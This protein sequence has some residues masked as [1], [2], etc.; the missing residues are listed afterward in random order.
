MNKVLFR[1]M[2]VGIGSVL[3]GYWGCFA[4]AG[5]RHAQPKTPVRRSVQPAPKPSPSKPVPSTSQPSS[6]SPVVTTPEGVLAALFDE[7]EALKN[8][9]IGLDSSISQHID[10]QKA[11]EGTKLVDEESQIK[12]MM[13]ISRLEQEDREFEV[14][15]ASIMKRLEDIEHQISSLLQAQAGQQA[16]KVQPMGIDAIV[17]AHS[18]AVPW[19]GKLL[20]RVIDPATNKEKIF[21]KGIAGASKLFADGKA[22]VIQ[23]GALG[24]R[25]NPDDTNNYCGYYV[26]F[27]IWLLMEAPDGL[28]GERAIFASMF[29]GMLQDMKQKG[30]R[31]PY[32]NLAEDEI[33][34]LLKNLGISENQY[35]FLTQPCI[36]CACDYTDETK[37]ILQSG[38]KPSAVLTVE[39]FRNRRSNDLYIIFNVGGSH[40]HWVAIH[41]HRGA[42]GVVHMYVVDSLNE[43]DWTADTIIRERLLPLYRFITGQ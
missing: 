43:V 27:N 18:V 36:A 26:A 22:Q 2:I 42:D 40:G 12:A 39:A 16:P 8:E 20:D 35:V 21:F 25:R 38:H 37:A 11:L 1:V 17:E 15:R 29:K 13:E 28:P 9:K 10:R 14:K 24:Q 30:V 5:R 34:A 32:D 3:T 23:L 4:A 19:D 6:S 33:E 7:Q 31:P 41:A